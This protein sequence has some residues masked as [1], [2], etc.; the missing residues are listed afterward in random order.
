MISYGFCDELDFLKGGQEKHGPS[1]YLSFG[2]TS[3]HEGEILLGVNRLLAIV[4]IIYAFSFHVFF[5]GCRSQLLI[6]FFLYI[7][8][9]N[10]NIKV[11]G[12]EVGVHVPF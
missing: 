4:Y 2:A 11:I 5:A 6:C 1:V 12:S 3:L 7:L 8:S 9:M 10:F